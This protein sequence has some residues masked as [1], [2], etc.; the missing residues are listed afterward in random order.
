MNNKEVDYTSNCN[1]VIE[2]KYYFYHKDPIFYPNFEGKI[3]EVYMIAKTNLIETD[4]ILE[5]VRKQSSEDLKKNE[6]KTRIK[7][8]FNQIKN[9]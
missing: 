8:Y 5:Y 3:T 2:K 6:L 9:K 7:L 4:K 1:E